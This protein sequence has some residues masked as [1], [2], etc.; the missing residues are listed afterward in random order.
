[1]YIFTISCILALGRYYTVYSGFSNAFS[2]AILFAFIPFGLSLGVIG[3]RFYAKLELQ[4]YNDNKDIPNPPFE[5]N[6]E[7]KIRI[8]LIISATIITLPYIIALTGL[9]VVGIN[10]TI[11]LLGIEGLKSQ[12]WPFFPTHLGLNHGWLGYFLIISAILNSKIE[13]LFK[14]SIVSDWIVFGFC[15]LAIWGSGWLIN[16]FI[17]EQIA[18]IFPGAYFP[19]L[20]PSRNDLFKFEL[21]LQ[22][23]IVFGLAY[24]MYYFGWK[25]YYRPLIINK[26]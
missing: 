11:P 20:T 3:D 2:F 7:D 17:S 13:K 4:N 22:I 25:K 5:L 15:F 1:M 21:L 10:I 19:F 26:S 6:K 23:I 16:D 24:I 18:P 8:L 12:I 14:L 9:S